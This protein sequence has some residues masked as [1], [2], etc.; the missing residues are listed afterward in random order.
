MDGWLSRQ[1]LRGLA[2]GSCVV[3]LAGRA[4]DAAAES[5]VTIPAEMTDS[6]L[7]FLQARVNGSQPL[8]FVLDSGAVPFFAID[9]RRAR[10]LGLAV[11]PFGTVGGGGGPNAYEVG[12]TRGVSIRLGDVEFA[13]QNPDVIALGPLEAIAG[14]PLDGLI[15]RDLF[16]RHVVE[17]DYVGSRIVLHDPRS[18]TDSKHGES[19]PLTMRNGHFFVPA[20][21][22]MPGQEP[23]DGRFLVDTGGG[24]VTAVLTAPFAK[25]NGLPARDRKTIADRSLAGLGGEIRL[26]ALRASSLMLGNLSLREP[27]VFIS[28]D[29]GGALASPD[30]DGLIGGGVLNRFTVTFDYSRR[31]LIL[32]PNARYR[33]PVEYDTSGIRLH[34][35]GDDLKTFRV[36]QL[37]ESSPAVEA[38]LRTGD[39]LTDIDGVAA[40]RLSLDEIYRLFKQP[41]RE[42]TIG[43]RRGGEALSAKIRTRPL[44]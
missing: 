3:A 18:Y 16:V 2:L 31:R 41:G 10:A 42:Y 21:I 17:I 38:G 44:I 11:E 29:E 33:E 14:R 15:G 27:V 40:S 13:D 4:L 5:T 9:A 1:V 37:L 12:R 36:H 24:F 8:W 35:E 32:E 43:F 30:Y 25:S 28:Q 22:T 7:I 23:L 26:L 19:L 6:G 34:A 20:R 39:V